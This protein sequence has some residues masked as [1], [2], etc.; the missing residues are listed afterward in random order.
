MQETLL[1]RN[2]D[3]HA[4]VDQQDGLAKLQVPVPQRQPLALER[5]DG[6][7]RPLE[8][9]EHGFRVAGIGARRGL[10]DHARRGPG[11]HVQRRHA[12]RIQFGEPA[13][14]LDRAPLVVRGVPAR[15]H[16]TCGA[17]DRP[18]V[19]RSI[20]Q[21]G[22]E[23]LAFVGRDEDII[24][25]CL[26]GKHGYLSLDQGHAAV[27]S[28]G[29]AG[30]LECSF[31]N[32]LRAEARGGASQRFG[33]KLVLLV[34]ADHQQPALPLLP[35]QILG[36]ARRR[37]SSA[38]GQ[39]GSHWRGNPARAAGPRSIRRSAARFRVRAAR[40]RPSTARRREDRQ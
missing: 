28:T 30:V 22:C 39:Y 1:R 36:Q 19:P 38:S 33:V 8:K 35:H 24:G 3:H 12:P 18:R 32:D 9:V 16:Q 13:L 20:G 25:W 27:G 11:L 21:V 26:L 34:R 2:R 14:H 29:A 15:R 23:D 31:L 7:V 17:C 10:A 4:S 5:R 40:R 6:K 37:A